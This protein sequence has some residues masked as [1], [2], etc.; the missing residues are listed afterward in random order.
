MKVSEDQNTVEMDD[1]TVG[2]FAVG[3]NC[4]HECIFTTGDGRCSLAP[5]GYTYCHGQY[6]DDGMTGNFKEVTPCE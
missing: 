6:R 2:V 3:G 4:D 1:G 5:T